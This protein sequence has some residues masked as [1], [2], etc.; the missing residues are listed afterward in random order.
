M[1]Y[2]VAGS[3]PGCSF[4]NSHY[5]RGAQEVL[6]MRAGGANSQLDIPY[7]TPLSVADCCPLQLL[8]L[9]WKTSVVYCK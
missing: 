2:I 8:V 4:T 9:H 7:L 5:A 1:S 3:I 6:P